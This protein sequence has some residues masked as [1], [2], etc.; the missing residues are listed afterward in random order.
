MAQSLSQLVQ[1]IIAN[2]TV[3]AD[4]ISATVPLKTLR[5]TVTVPDTDAAD[6]IILGPIPVHAIINQLEVTTADLGSAGT[7]D[8][9]VFRPNYS[10]ATVTFEVV[11]KD[12]IADGLDVTQAVSSAIAPQRFAGLAADSIDKKLYEIAGQTTR[13]S[14]PMFYIGLTTDT[15]TTVAGTVTINCSYT[16]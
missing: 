11:D 13:P 7:I 9:G 5:D 6:T 16:V 15:G 1:N 14:Y 8:I 12:C 3:A 4:G 10:G 2:P